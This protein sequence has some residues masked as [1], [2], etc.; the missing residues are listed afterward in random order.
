MIS[1]FIFLH[2]PQSK[3]CVER[4]KLSEELEKKVLSGFSSSKVFVGYVKD[5]IQHIK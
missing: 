4:P 2:I 5:F 1:V 3:K